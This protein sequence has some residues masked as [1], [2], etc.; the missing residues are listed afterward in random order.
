VHAR[1]C[2]QTGR[3]TF[4]LVVAPLDIPASTGSPVN[5]VAIF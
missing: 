5:P 3:S 2:T 1:V 4:S